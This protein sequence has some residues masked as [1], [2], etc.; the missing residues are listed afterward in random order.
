MIGEKENKIGGKFSKR[1]RKLIVVGYTINGIFREKDIKNDCLGTRID[2]EI[3]RQGMKLTRPWSTEALL[4]H[5]AKGWLI[6][7][8]EDHILGFDT[9]TMR[10]HHSKIVRLHLPR[11]EERKFRECPGKQGRNDTYNEGN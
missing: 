6:D 2:T 8:K 11:L 3:D 7:I 5:V 9:A 10:R 4:F 1:L